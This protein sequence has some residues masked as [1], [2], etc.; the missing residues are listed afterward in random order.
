MSNKL[1][2][3]IERPLS[4]E[5][6]AG[7][8]AIIEENTAAVFLAVPAEDLEKAGARRWKGLS[9]EEKKA[10]NERLFNKL[11]ALG[12]ATVG[13]DTVAGHLCHK[14][15]PT[16]YYH[17]FRINYALQQQLYVIEQYAL[18]LAAYEQVVVYTHTVPNN[19]LEL[20]VNRIL[21]IPAK[22]AAEKAKPKTGGRASVWPQLRQMS[23]RFFA[24]VKQAQSRKSE[25]P[26][27]LF[28]LNHSHLRQILNPDHLP[29]LYQDNF[30]VGYFLKD[31]SAN[32]L[33]ID[34]LLLEKGSTTSAVNESEASI[35]YQRNPLN[36]ELVEWTALLDPKVLMKLL[37][38]HRHLK[39]TYNKLFRGVKDPLDNLII[40][41]ITKLHYSSL[42]FFFTYQAYRRFFK[43]HTFK[44]VS[45]LDE[46][47]PN[48]RAIIDAAKQ[49]GVRTQAIQHGILTA[50]TPGYDYSEQ[51]IR[52]NPWPDRT[53]LWGEVWKDLLM[54]IGAYPPEKLWVCGQIRTDVIPRLLQTSLQAQQI[55][56]HQTS[57]KFL[58]LF[59]TQPQPD[60][61]LRKRAALDV[62]S[63]AKEL[64]DVWVILKPHPR[65]RDASYY[66]QLAKESGCSNYSIHYEE[67]LFLLLRLCHVLVHCFSTV[68]VEAVYFGLPAIILDYLNEDVLLFAAEEVALQALDA[69]AL[70]QHLKAVQQGNYH[71]DEIKR[72]A[73]INK[74]ACAIDG[75]VSE[76]TAQ[77]LLGD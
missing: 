25:M 26:E 72:Q 47:S 34:K 74:Y 76:R 18:L 54:Q 77:A 63:V 1:A 5:E 24:G 2:Y 57:G 27:H 12:H 58:I 20:E 70:Y 48:F 11:H 75:K 36:N 64:S 6:V 35:Y 51:D 42:Y 40:K 52:F 21:F 33:L 43:N 60:E 29:A 66:H 31:W 16:W 17:K 69:E 19:L 4:E 67:D 62:F 44:T 49:E 39:G 53:L 15:F 32:F 45:L 23:L 30:L 28:V 55:L 37:G 14:G 46:Y 73:Y 8:L 3:L 38:F 61:L 22:V 13:K 9:A 10:V 68:G 59:A 41:E 50:T 7:F 56:G 65:E 71:L